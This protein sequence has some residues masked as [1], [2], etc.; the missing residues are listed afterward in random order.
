MKKSEIIKLAIK[1]NFDESYLS[2]IK[3]PLLKRAFAVEFKKST[4]ITIVLKT[5]IDNLNKDAAI[6]NIVPKEKKKKSQPFASSKG[7]CGWGKHATAFGTRL[8]LSD[9]TKGDGKRGGVPH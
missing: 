4:D 2:G 8:E 3:A 5:V 1:N 7:S 9:S 6:Y